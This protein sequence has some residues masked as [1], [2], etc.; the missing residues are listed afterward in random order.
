[1]G[2]ETHH[3][4]IEFFGSAGDV[5]IAAVGGL[6][7]IFLLIMIVICIGPAIVRTLRD[8]NQGFGGKHRALPC[9]EFVGKQRMKI[10]HSIHHRIH[11]FICR[12]IGHAH[13]A[14]EAR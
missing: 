9:T 4:Q 1:M 2:R 5:A 10:I 3:R 7:Y 12:I 14:A 8:L 11:R 13:D 6:Q